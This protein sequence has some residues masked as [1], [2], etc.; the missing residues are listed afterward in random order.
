LTLENFYGAIKRAHGGSLPLNADQRK[1]IEHGYADPLWMIAGPGT[2]KTHTL[3]WLVFKRILVDGVA[4]ERIFLTTFTRK[5]AAE[6]ESRLILSR[7]RLMQSGCTAASRIEIP[8]IYLGTLH[9]LC[10]RVLQD[11]RYEP[12]FRIRILEDELVQQFFVRRSNNSLFQ[13]DDPEFWNRFGLGRGDTYAPNKAAKAEGISKL[14]NRM[15][16]NSADVQAM[17]D[18]GD[19]DLDGVVDVLSG[20]VSDALHLPMATSEEDIE[21][22]DYKS[23]DQPRKGS[24]Q[25]RDYEYQMRVY[26]ELYKQQRGEYP[27]RAVL[28]FLG[29]LNDDRRWA[30]AAGDPASY[31]RLFYPIHP[32]PRGIDKALQ[33]FHQT[34]EEIEMERA[35]R[36]ADQW[37]PPTHEVDLATCEACEI[38]FNCSNYAHAAQDRAHPL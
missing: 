29:E 11:E 6:L 22:W 18:S 7:E 8:S 5:A 21:I 36:Y 26:L 34:V 33:D 23:G 1:A 27:A 16:E 4:P 15:T 30:L 25:L 28:A 9:S 2:G 13:N 24:R 12:T 3:T 31:P 20:A 14:F 19:E 38:R 35:R 32:D 37:N 10:S 17:L